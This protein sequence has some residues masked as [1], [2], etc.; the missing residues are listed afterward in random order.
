MVNVTATK[1]RDNTQPRS[2]SG[3]GRPYSGYLIS[4]PTVG[5]GMVIFRDP[6]GHRM[7]TTPVRRVLSEF[8]AS[9]IYVETEN[10]VYRLRFRSGPVAENAARTTVNS[11]YQGR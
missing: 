2:G 10:S 5:R 11:G 9:D 1:I 6:S 8:G 4:F 7:V 3:L